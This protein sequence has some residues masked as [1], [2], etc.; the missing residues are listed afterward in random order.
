MF[1]SDKGIWLL[2]RDLS[3]SYIGAPVEDLTLTA[4]VESA[5]N[6][7]ATNQ[8][9]FTLNSGITLMYDYY[10]Q[11][12]GTFVNVPAISST[13]YNGL[14]TFINDSGSVFQETPGV[15]LDGGNPVL[16]SFTTGWINVAGLQGYERA[17]FLYLLAQ[18]IT[19]HKLQVAISY[20]YEVSPTQIS[21][22]TPDNYS[23]AWGGDALWG[24]NQVWGGP[25]GS[26]EQ[27]RVILQ[28]QRC[29]AFQVSVTE[30]Y[31][32]TYGIAAGAGFTM[33]GLLAVVGIKKGYTTL[34][35]GRTV[36]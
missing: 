29:Q 23:P 16:L 33:S 31:D 18:Y 26:R 6:V 32:P 34:R 3:T 21:L 27:W 24:S 5:I 9:R 7:P 28:K 11:Q 19:P 25:N 8:I 20:D 22:I 15:Y 14:H 17:Y 1:Q 36:G 10:Y 2:G 4:T 30:S 35:P 12:W 13:L